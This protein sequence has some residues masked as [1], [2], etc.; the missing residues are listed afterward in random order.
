MAVEKEKRSMSLR[1]RLLIICL[2][3]LGIP[4]LLIGLVG[5]ERSK[6]ELD[7]AG[8]DRLKGNV[9]MVLGMIAL[10]QKEVDAGHLKLEDAQNRLRDEILGNQ[11]GA[12]ISDRSYRNI[13]WEK[14][15]TLG[16]SFQRASAS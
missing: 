2:L 8:M 16:L 9:Q 15:A 13:R 6:V 4:S 5:Y 11:K 10:L 12:I 3:L 14:R 7:H 1:S